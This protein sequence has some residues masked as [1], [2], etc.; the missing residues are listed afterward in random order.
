[1][2]PAAE[3]II[4]RFEEKNIR[5]RVQE[6]E[7]ST[8]II[9]DVIV[10]YTSFSVV[11]ITDSDDND[12]AVRVP[13]YV[14]FL[15]KNRAEVLRVCNEMNVKYRFCK[16]SLNDSVGSVTMEYDLPTHTE[17]IGDA[18]VEIFQR[19]MQIAEEA[20]PYYMRAIW[21]SKEPAVLGNIVFHD[22]EVE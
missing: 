9:A 7:E 3:E 11:Y 2:F 18:A 13:H 6:S 16:F 1:M 5:F 8:R 20:F 4:E 14:R 21:A 10:D 17:N 15:E 19:V 22:Y 12:V